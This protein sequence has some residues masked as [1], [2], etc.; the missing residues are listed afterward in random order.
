[1]PLLLKV[2]S[3]NPKHSRFRGRGH[4][5]CSRLE[6]ANFDQSLRRNRTPDIASA[7]NRY[8]MHF[9]SHPSCTVQRRSFAAKNLNQYNLDQT[10]SVECPTSAVHLKRQ[11]AVCLS[12]AVAAGDVCLQRQSSSTT[13]KH[14]LR[15]GCMSNDP[16]HQLNLN[17]KRN[18]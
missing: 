15:R 16:Y 7:N 13:N 17:G 10:A 2:R 1:M 9:A 8:L 12:R 6:V 5:I 18:S 3:H 11:V 4:V 14:P